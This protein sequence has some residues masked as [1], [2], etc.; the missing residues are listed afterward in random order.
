MVGFYVLLYT[1]LI[2]VDA[3]GF[4]PMINYWDEFFAVAAIVWHIVKR[5]RIRCGQYEILNYLLLLVVMLAGLAGNLF[6]PGIQKTSAAIWKD[7]FAFLKF[8][9]L[10][11]VLHDAAVGWPE[12]KRRI[13]IHWAGR[14]TK[15]LVILEALA[16][17]VGYVV[18][19]GVYT[20]EVRITRC[21]QF[22]FSHPTFLVASLSIC[23]SLLMLEGRKKNRS[24]IYLCCGLL[25][26][27]QRMKAYAL[28]AFV[29]LF[30]LIK[31]SVIRKCFSFVKKTKIKKRYFVPAIFG[32]A[33]VLIFVFGKRFQTYLSWGMSS[34]RIAL[35]VVAVKISFDF[36]P[37][38]SGF[39]T[40]ASFLSGKYYSTIY[41]IYGISRVT[42]LRR[43]YY[44]FMS[45]T[46]WP[47]V[48]GEFGI[49][50]FLGYLALIVRLIVRQFSRIKAYDKM[51]AFLSL[52]LYALVASTSEAFFTNATGV[53]LALFLSLYIGTDR[54]VTQSVRTF[55]MFTT[56]SGGSTS[57][58]E[59]LYPLVDKIHD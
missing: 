28:I 52:W 39:G 23:V 32:V 33:I 55:I 43:E 20:S 41:D 18:D 14:I 57:D 53:A 46:F 12:G 44:G 11:I 48:L 13:M 16:A 25:F 30:M 29:L 4:I 38:G 27:T 54:K 10:M 8:P 6:H 40:F 35:Y 5:E 56:H 50:A 31:E 51:V 59:K 24:L 19:I 42:G 17:L 37:F 15:V 22:L 36:F 21:Y 45:D 1:F 49:L 9:L 26:L 34:A 2:L 47:W 58:E 3:L 7:V